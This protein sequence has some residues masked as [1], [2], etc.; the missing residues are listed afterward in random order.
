VITAYL[1]IGSSIEPEK[2]LREALR[3]LAARAKVAAVS[4]VYRTP[5]IDRPAD[6]PFYNCV[7]SVQ[8]L[9][10]AL[11]FKCGVLRKIE[12]DLGRHRGPDKY[13]RRTIDLDLILYGDLVIDS[14]ELHLPDPE[15]LKRPFLIVCLH[16]LAPDLRL[17]GSGVSI[18][19]AAA[20]A[21][22]DG[23]AALPQYT[24]QLRHELAMIEAP[25]KQGHP[26]IP[27]KQGRYPIS[28]RRK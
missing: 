15:I 21:P 25:E 1:S 19:E 3:R 16:E 11:E 20:A 6:P 23:L 18:A 17:P 14:D 4:T 24:A 8:T 22:R 12:D 2:N 7:A 26:S 5:A 13:A 9:L 10:P 27:E 28:G